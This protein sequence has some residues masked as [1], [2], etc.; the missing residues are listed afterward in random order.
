MIGKIGSMVVVA[1]IIANAAR[2]FLGVEK[3]EVAKR[4]N[5]RMADFMIFPERILAS[6]V[7]A[8]W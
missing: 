3:G 5:I 7:P 8:S 2:V 6:N 4:E 1:E